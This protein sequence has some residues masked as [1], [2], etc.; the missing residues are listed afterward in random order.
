MSEWKFFNDEW[1]VG[2]E[3]NYKQDK[4]DGVNI[5][6][7]AKGSSS[8]NSSQKQEKVHSQGKTPKKLGGVK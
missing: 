2:Q 1:N 5:P 8:S 6:G 7:M 4:R 3:E